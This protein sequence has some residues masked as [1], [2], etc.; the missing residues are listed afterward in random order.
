MSLG[1]KQRP[2][3]PLA[4]SINERRRLILAA[5][6]KVFVEQG[7]GASTMEEIARAAEMSKKTLYQF[8]ADKQAVFAALMQSEEMPVFPMIACS[9]ARNSSQPLR[10]TMITVARFILEPRHIA[11]TRLVIAEA[12]KYP[13]L[14]SSFYNN[15]MDRFKTTLRE[16]LVELERAAVTGAASAVVLAEPLMGATIGSFHMKALLCNQSFSDDEI[17]RRVDLALRVFGVI[18][19]S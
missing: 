16:R 8:F 5:A 4:Y 1:L 13:E 17:E 11:L 15:Y 3:R 10:D 7:Y 12:P 2:G 18:S 9:A 14:A 6:E 19:A